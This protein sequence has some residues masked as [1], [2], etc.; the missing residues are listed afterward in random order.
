MALA[1]LEI[2][3]RALHRG[4]ETDA[5]DF[6]VSFVALGHTDDHVGDQALGG[7]VE[8][9]DNAV[10][11]FTGDADAFGI[12]AHGDSK[13]ERPSELTFGAFDLHDAVITDFDGDFIWDGN[14]KFAD[15]GHGSW[16]R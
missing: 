12:T 8:G 14:G 1:E 9:T 16:V 3:V 10:F 2:D 5:M 15:A 4:A 7:A 13:R 11:G 6:K